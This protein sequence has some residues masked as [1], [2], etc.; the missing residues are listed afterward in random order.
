[1]ILPLSSRLAALLRLSNASGR[2]SV[3]LCIDSTM[4]PD[5][6]GSQPVTPLYYRALYAV[7]LTHCRV[8][9]YAIVV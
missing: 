1:M 7:S 5:S 8:L 9:Y 6:A 2:P 4:E 3:I